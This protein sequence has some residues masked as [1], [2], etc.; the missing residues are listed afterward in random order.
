MT[1]DI[2]GYTSPDSHFESLWLECPNL[3]ARGTGRDACEIP[4]HPDKV[5]KV[6]NRQSNYSN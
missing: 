4:G 6:S 3:I 5:L 1:I 2:P